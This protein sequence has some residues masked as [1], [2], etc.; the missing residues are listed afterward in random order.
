[1]AAGSEIQAK[2]GQFCGHVFSS[3]SFDVWHKRLGHMSCNK[4]QIVPDVVLVSEEIRN[5]VCEV[6]PKSKQSRLP[7]PHSKTVVRTA[8]LFPLMLFNY[9][10]WTPGDHIIQKPIQDIGIF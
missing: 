2:T 8:K 9:Y 4:M 3:V 6:C 1:M 10:M 5:F 7:F